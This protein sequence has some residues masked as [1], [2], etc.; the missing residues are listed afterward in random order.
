MTNYSH[1]VIARIDTIC[2][3][4]E[5]SQADPFIQ[6]IATGIRESIHNHKD[7]DTNTTIQELQPGLK[8]QHKPSTVMIGSL[9]ALLQKVKDERFQHALSQHSVFHH[10]EEQPK[11]RLSNESLK[12]ITDN[13][14]TLL[15]D[16]AEITLMPGYMHQMAQK[17]LYFLSINSNDVDTV[18]GLLELYIPHFDQ[19]KN[20]D[21]QSNTFSVAFKDNELLEFNAEMQKLVNAATQGP[22]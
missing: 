18:K 8:Q 16:K 6:V 2:T 14:R 9:V 20:F 22:R 10:E 4:P 21:A 13:L 15:G 11:E 3:M 1:E 12:V 19:S 5:F 17:P 7:I